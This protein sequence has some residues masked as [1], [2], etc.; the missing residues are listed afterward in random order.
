MPKL[1][2]QT[3]STLH[4]ENAQPQHPPGSPRGHL[5]THRTSLGTTPAWGQ[6]QCK[7]R[8]D[9]GHPHKSSLDPCGDEGQEKKTTLPLQVWAGGRDKREAGT[10]LGAPGQGAGVSR[11]AP[12]G[13]ERGLAWGNGRA[14]LPAVLEQRR[15]SWP[16]PAGPAEPRRRRWPGRGSQEHPTPGEVLS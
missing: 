16:Q 10:G 8:T 6:G 11:E 15:P 5:G 1:W 13:D 4:R 12:S 7:N 9:E 2:A 3:G 14:S